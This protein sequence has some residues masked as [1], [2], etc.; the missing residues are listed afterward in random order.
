MINDTKKLAVLKETTSNL[1]QT[2][3]QVR[4]PRK[5]PATPNNCLPKINLIPNEKL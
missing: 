1:Q 3:E 4:K 2:A 5:Y